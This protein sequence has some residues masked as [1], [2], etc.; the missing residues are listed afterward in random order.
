MSEP[1]RFPWRREDLEALL[2]PIG[3][4]VDE[5]IAA[6][7]A[8]H[9]DARW[10]PAH[11]S[12]DCRDYL[13]RLMDLATTRPLTPVEC[14]LYWQLLARFEQAIRHEESRRPRDGLM[15]PMEEDEATNE[16]LREGGRDGP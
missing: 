15:D 10:L 1:G 7:K 9:P 13:A 2:P 5:R 16:E 14:F 3:A 12:G 6:Y 8:E 4:S 11:R